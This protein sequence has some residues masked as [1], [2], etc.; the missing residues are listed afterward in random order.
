VVRS[1]I[2]GVAIILRDITA[3]KKA[4]ESIRESNVQLEKQVSERTK[5]LE[6][7]LDAA[8]AVSH[9]KSAFISSVSHEMRTPLNG[10]VGSLDLI[11]EEGL[12]ENQLSY[13]NLTDISIHNLSNLVNDILDLSKIEAGKL[14]V[15]QQAF[16]ILQVVEETITMFQPIAVEKGIVLLLDVSQ[17]S[18][19][20][21]IGDG[22]R[23][24]QILNNLLSNASKFTDNGYIKVTPSTKMLEGSLLFSCQVQDTG[25]GIAPHRQADIFKAF[26]QANISTAHTYGG[27]GLGLSITKQLCHLMNGQISLKSEQGKGSEFDFS[28]ILGCAEAGDTQVNDINTAQDD[29]SNTYHV[30]KLL[31]GVKAVLLLNN[32]D[33]YSLIMQNINAYGGEVCRSLDDQGV[34][35][36]IAEELYPNIS[37]INEQYHSRR[38][39]SQNTSSQ[40][41]GSQD[42]SKVLWVDYGS[43]RQSPRVELEGLNA[44]LSKPLAITQLLPVISAF[45]SNNL[46]AA[47]KLKSLE[48][49]NQQTHLVFKNCD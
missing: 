41:S 10:I 1:Q 18:Y 36:I 16:D 29:L 47:N 30:Q 7:A 25:I 9:T 32:T 26:E 33:E 24:R 11:R 43:I 46:D 5:Q 4:Q 34:N 39:S 23:V 21:A 13:L 3:E 48:R 22:Y 2:S 12:S 19:H 45:N 15:R 35:L 40:S 20:E 31:Q 14:E 49:L 27:T 8:Q 17:L 44:S 28:L 6:I 37:L 42:R 38:S